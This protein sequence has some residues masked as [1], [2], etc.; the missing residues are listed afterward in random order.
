[1]GIIFH[2]LKH[3]AIPGE[4]AGHTNLAKT[5]RSEAELS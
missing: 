5:S 3:Q 1:M 2:Q 4:Q